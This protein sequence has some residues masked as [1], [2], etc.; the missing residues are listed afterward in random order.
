MGG[1]ACKYLNLCH[2]TQVQQAEAVERRKVERQR[3]F[4]PPLE[5]PSSASDG[6]TAHTAGG[7]T[8]QGRERG[9]DDINVATIKK[10]VSKAL[11]K[12]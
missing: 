9:G 6:E 8:Q 2:R 1:E 4:Q 7:A 12:V 5:K 11:K 3:V 10:K